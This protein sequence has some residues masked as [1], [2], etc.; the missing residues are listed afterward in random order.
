MPTRS[1]QL[2]RRHLSFSSRLQRQPA[3]EY[4]FPCSVA[5]LVHSLWAWHWSIGSLI[6]WSK[7][8]AELAVCWLPGKSLTLTLTKEI[9]LLY[10]RYHLSIKVHTMGTAQW[11][12]FFQVFKSSIVSHLVQAELTLCGSSVSGGMPLFVVSVVLFFFWCRISYS[13]G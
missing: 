9:C 12:V 8:L 13:P 6:Q 2:E 3:P 5:I 10:F 7:V 11:Y 4:T 1:L